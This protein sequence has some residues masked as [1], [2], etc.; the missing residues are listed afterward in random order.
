MILG[1]DISTSTTGWAVIKSDGALVNQGYISTGKIKGLFEKAKKVATK[2]SKINIDYD[3]DKI[4]IEENLQAFRSGFS[5]AQTISTLAKFNG[6][7]SYVCFTEF[8]FEPA[9][10][11][12]N[13]ARKTLGIKIEREKV[14]GISTKDQVFTWVRSALD[15]SGYVWPVKT[16]KSG[17]RKGKTVFINECFDISDAY[18][19][20]LSGLRV[21]N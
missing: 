19:I 21:N 9:F 18:V 17:P 8:G 2:I 16:L 5:S 7:V 15:D 10:L 20:G 4:Y 11:N 14:C 3:I 13:S 6:I 12:V 1:L